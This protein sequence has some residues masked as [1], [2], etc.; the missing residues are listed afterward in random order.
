MY[1]TLT[2]WT[3]SVDEGEFDENDDPSVPPGRQLSSKLVAD[4]EPHIESVT[5]CSQHSYYGWT[6][7]SRFKGCRFINVIN[8]V[9][10]DVY[11]T[12]KMSWY[13]LKSLVSSRPH[14]IFDEYCDVLSRVVSNLEGTT[15]QEWADYA[16]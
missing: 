16:S 5:E 15:S 4:L 12:V 3:T 8:P 11:L 9:D 10:D 13:G 6:F 14:R 7:D 1:R 2:F